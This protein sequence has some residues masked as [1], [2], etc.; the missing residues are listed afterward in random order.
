MHAQELPERHYIQLSQEYAASRDHLVTSLQGAG[1]KSFMPDDGY[2]VMTDISSF[3]L[4]DDASFVHHL[5]THVGVA[6]VPGSS[7]FQVFQM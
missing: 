6:A 7:F 3:G 4:A 5:T 2:Y 1:F